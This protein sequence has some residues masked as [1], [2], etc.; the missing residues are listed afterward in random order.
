MH[1]F[2][3][4]GAIHCSLATTLSL[5][6]FMVFPRLTFIGVNCALNV[7]SYP[8]GQLLECGAWVSCFGISCEALLGGQ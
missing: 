7:V 2:S 8:D 5:P 4:L 1:T 3:Y 6:P